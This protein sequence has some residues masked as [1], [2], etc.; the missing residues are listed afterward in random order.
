MRVALFVPCYIDQ[1]YPDVGMATLELL[2]RYGCHVEFPP[3]QTCCGQ[4]MAN[5]GCRDDA[6]PL[7]RRFVEIFSGYDAIVCPSGS[8][9]AMVTHHYET[10][11]RE[12][13]P[14]YTAVQSKTYELTQFLVDV[15]K[16]KISDIRFPYR[17]GLHQ[18]CHGLRD[19]RLGSCSERMM[20][21][22]N[23][24]EM[25]LR[26]V[27]DLTLV[28]L[29][30]KDEC[31]G[32]GGTFAVSEE[33]VSCMMGNDRIADHQ[34]AGTQVMTAGDM[35]CLMHLEG[36]LRRQKIPIAVMHISQIL[37]GRQ[38]TL[39]PVRNREKIT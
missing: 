34:Q 36:L 33:A 23:K 24:A 29:S 11:F 10:F 1:M 39:N 2:E 15:L 32:F 18:S 38:P 37:A 25:L 31:C 14:A 12:H 9:V 30:R 16:V 22:E 17:V 8:C 13:D 5:T 27:N 20:A 6:A 4:P 28:D 19:L 35:S 7:A 26:Q 21:F 3:A